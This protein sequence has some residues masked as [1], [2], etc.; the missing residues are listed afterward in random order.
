GEVQ[1]GAESGESAADDGDVA[2]ER[3]GERR[4]VLR[5][6]GRRRVVGAAREIAV[7]LEETHKSYA[8]GKPFEGSAPRSCAAAPHC[9]GDF[10]KVARRSPAGA[11]R[12]PPSS[13]RPRDGSPGPGCR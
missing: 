7:G 3:A 4:M 6:G 9:D 10:G 12:R 1:G 8:L 2:A 5:A 11:G 13:I